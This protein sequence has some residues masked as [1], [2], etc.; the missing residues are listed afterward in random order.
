MTN[1]SAIMV[2]E[3]DPDI[4]DAITAVLEDNGYTV[5]VAGNGQEALDRLRAAAALPRMIL[6]DLTMPVLDGR[7]FRTAQQADPVL[8]DIPVIL[9]SAQMDVRS[10]AEEMGARAWLSK[11]VD[12]RSLL[13]LIA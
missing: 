5:L 4:S 13:Q 10:A 7:Q 8:A 6:L 3:D 9:L 12:V 2:V 1:T 11:P